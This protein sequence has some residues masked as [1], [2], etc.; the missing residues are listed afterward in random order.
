M[1]KYRKSSKTHMWNKKVPLYFRGMVYEHPWS[2]KLS[3]CDN[4]DWNG[5]RIYL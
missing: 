3:L 2:N 1:G 5:V 4:G